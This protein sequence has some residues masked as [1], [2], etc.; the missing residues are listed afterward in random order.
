MGQIYY[1]LGLS[2]GCIIH[3]AAFVYDPTANKDKERDTIG[4]FKVVEDYLRPVSRK[5]GYLA[6][7]NYGTNNE[8]G[9]DYLK[10]NMAYDK[11]A[12]VQRAYNYAISDEGYS[13]LIDE[14]R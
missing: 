1:A 11:D 8:F 3:D 7:I 10:D 13:N 2:V 6:D 9:F 4:A 5:E 12:P 14:A